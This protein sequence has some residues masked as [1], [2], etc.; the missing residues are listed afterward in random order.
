[1]LDARE[2]PFAFSMPSNKFYPPHI[3]E[4]QSLLRTGLLSGKLPRTIKAK[5]AVIVEAQAGQGKTTLIS[6]FLSYNTFDYIWYQIGPEDADPIL[7]LSSL[8]A[9]FSL[10][11]PDFRSPQ[12]AAILE[13]GEIGPLDLQ[14]CANLLLT[15]LDAFLRQDLYVVFDD[16]HLIS[17]AQFTTSL[18]DHLIDTSPPR[19]HFVLSTRHP[20]SLKAKTLRDG[21][22]IS[23][24]KTSDLALD[25]REIEELFTTVFDRT[26]TPQDALDIHRLTNGWVMGIVLASHPITG[27]SRFWQQ[28]QVSLSHD[29]ASGEQ[30]HMLD[31]F[32]DEI[33]DK[34]P[35]SL[36]LA[37][38]RLSF[39]SEIPVELAISLT[40]IEDFGETLAS[41]ARENFSSIASTTAVRCTVSIISSRSFCNSRPK[42]GSRS[43]TCEQFTPGRRN[44][45]LA[46]TR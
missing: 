19:L 46:A 5:K 30:G 18:L 35:S 25:R 43:R 28:P 20:L 41:M 13:K 9:D 45:I 2:N 17:E 39:L 37:F 21:S 40:G 7:L 26:I 14:R 36:H 4:S 38:L 23:Y 29:L 8:L 31:Y 11:F 10:K 24:L 32:Q 27:R 33:F 6:Q 16:L 34:I 22:R 1:M 44:I 12:L 42:S 15:D 3:D